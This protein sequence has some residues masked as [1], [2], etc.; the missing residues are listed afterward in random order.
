MKHLMKMGAYILLGGI[1]LCGLS[2]CH[3]D[4]PDYSNVVPP[5][6]ADVHNISGS[7]AGIDGKGIQGATITMSGKASGTTTTDANGY[8][9]FE[10]VAVGDYDLN[11]SATGKISKATSVSVTN[12]GN[13]KNVVWNV[14]LA[15]EEAVTS[16]TIVQ[17]QSGS[18]DVTSEALQGNDNAE[19]PVNVSVPANA[20]N[21][22]A[23]IEISPIYNKDDASTAAKAAAKVA[24][25]AST[26]AGDDEEILIGAKLS[27]SD[28]TVKIQNPIDLAFTVDDVTTSNVSV[29]KYSDGQ[30]VNVDASK[31]SVESGKVIVKADEFTSYGLFC[32]IKF[33]VSSTTKAI[34]FTQDEWDN[35]YG[36]GNMSVGTATYSYSIGMDISLKQSSNVFLA[37][38]IEAMAREYGANSYT[39]QGNY[40]LNVTLPVG[41]ALKVS[42]VQQINTVKASV[43]SSFSVT[44]T[45]YGDVTIT[46]TTYNRSHTGGSGGSK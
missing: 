5:T 38:L 30:W 26:R 46:V 15:S 9:V 28:A 36:S 39:T 44:G 32:G 41:T 33:T 10:N 27:C 34:T 3:D 14:M 4:D 20:T 13:G 24:S 6:V 22:S 21:K 7:V 45:Q 35:L 8:F 31:Y 25:A 29:K 17:G 42:G 43:G 37:L 1:T 12:T 40:P 16:V 2:S 11:V 19:I 18:G 23:T